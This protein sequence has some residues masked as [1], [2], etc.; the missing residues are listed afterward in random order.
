VIITSLATINKLISHSEITFDLIYAIL[1]PNSIVVTRCA[2][3]GLPRLFKLTSWQRVC[4]NAMAMYQLQMESVDLVDRAATRSVVV[5]KIQTVVYLRPVRGTVKIDSL[6]ACPIK[7]HL[8]E[9]EL[10]DTC[11][12]RRKKWVSLIGVHHK[13]YDGNAATKSCD[14]L[15]RHSVGLFSFHVLVGWPNQPDFC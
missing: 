5:G 1:I 9:E 3:T 12:K 14:S 8:N 11:L 2:I 7:F 6:D 13:Q 15:S 10:R 4:I